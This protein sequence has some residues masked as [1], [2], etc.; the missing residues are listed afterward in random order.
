MTGLFILPQNSG[1]TKTELSLNVNVNYH[2]HL[3]V[4]IISFLQTSVE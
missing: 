2:C 3:G 4:K 1:T